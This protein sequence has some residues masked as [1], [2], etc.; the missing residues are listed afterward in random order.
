MN[1]ECV[2]TVQASP[3]N[4][5]TFTINN[6]DIQYSDA[7]SDDYL[8]IREGGPS[9]KLY[10]VYCGTEPDRNVTTANAIWIKFK[11][12]NDGTAK[13]FMAQYSYAYHSEIVASEGVVTNPLYP[14]SYVNEPQKVTYRITVPFGYVIAINFEELQIGNDQCADRIEFYDGFD[15]NSPKIGDGFCGFTLPKPFKSTSNVLYIET[16]DLIVAVI[17]A[18]YKFSFKAVQPSKE[19]IVKT[20]EGC[21]YNDIVL[22]NLTQVINITSPGYP[23]GYANSLNC[24]WVISSVRP[25]FHPTIHLID[26]DLDESDN[27]VGDYLKISTSNDVATWNELS[28]VC[29]SNFRTTLRPQMFEGTPNLK[30][31]FISDFHGNRT[32]FNSLVGLSCG[33][34]LTDPNGVISSGNVT[35]I[36]MR[37][38]RTCI[39]QIKVR[40]GRQIKFEF[41]YLNLDKRDERCS[42]YMLIKNGLDETSPLLDN[43]GQ[44]CGTDPPTLNL[45]S[46]RYAYIKVVNNNLFVNTYH[47]RY[48]EVRPDCGGSFTLTDD[49]S[50]F[51]INSPNYPN[52]PNP[53]MECI[54]L[55]IAPAGEAMTITFINKFDMLGGICLK[56]YIELRDGG[57]SRAEELGTYCGYKNPPQTTTKSNMLRV[58]YFTDTD[59]PKS[60]FQANVT[61]AKCGG[62]YRSNAGYI[63]SPGFGRKGSYPPNTVCDYRIEAQTQAIVS[64]KFLS[65]DLPARS[66]CSTVDHVSI[67]S[68]VSNQEDQSNETL[69]L[70]G[71]Y[72]GTDDIPEISGNSNEILIRFETFGA[73]GEHVGFRIKFNS[74]V[75]QCGGEINAE[76]G[77]I[78]SPGYPVRMHI[79]RSCD[80]RITVPKGRRVVANIVDLDIGGEGGVFYTNRITFYNGLVT[81][82]RIRSVSNS[83]RTEVV[84][85]SDNTMLIVLFV[86]QPSMNRGFKI[87]FT[88]NETTICDGSL[89][90]DSGTIYSPMNQSSFACEYIRTR[91]IDTVNTGTLVFEFKDVLAGQRFINKCQWVSSKIIVRWDSSPR[92][93][94]NIMLAMCGPNI[95]DSTVR[96][97]FM[98]TVI[99][100]RQS[101]YGGNINFTLNY[102]VN[103]CGGIIRGSAIISNPT[104]KPSSTNSVGCAWYIYH[105]EG[106]TFHI[107]VSC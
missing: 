75:S 5:V 91:S 8:E 9:G 72:C 51:V 3:G 107:Q 53:H 47:L 82:N 42:S 34:V 81:Y 71:H 100:A 56:E 36:V 65:I 73:I 83:N 31:E 38:S 87:L 69:L 22:S 76:S 98:G 7:C 28:R 90:N 48:S 80:W 67:Y 86:R 12:G 54:W 59:D 104:T 14:R 61:L 64:L 68:V 16:A 29:N 6:L 106:I 37:P 44:I 66:N 19:A 97:P 85:S 33:G 84:K 24:T 41:D 15:S 105:D 94:E 1:V 89:D 13:G 50:Y 30:L 43:Y 49:F 2:W 55:F 58:K 32:G 70:H 4:I 21:G 27:C 26:V 35:T 45:T 79:T 60:G 92:K 95:L 96:T 10:G 18:L 101:L 40:P 102:W 57:T 20:V 93:D 62:L 17:N 63:K 99:D 88:S 39:Y 23:F 25:D 77:E 46:G 103:K 52:I 74:T 78:V 11:S